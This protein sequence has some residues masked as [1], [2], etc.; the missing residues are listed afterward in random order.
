MLLLFLHT[1]TVAVRLFADIATNSANGS[2]VLQ[3]RYGQNMLKIYPELTWML[4]ET[5]YQEYTYGDIQGWKEWWPSVF[6]CEIHDQRY[7]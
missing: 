4:E 2:G 7:D 3:T 5:L 1:T 6:G